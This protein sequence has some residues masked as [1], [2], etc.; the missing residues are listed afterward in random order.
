MN[1]ILGKTDANENVIQQ[2]I[3]GYPELKRRNITFKYQPN[4]EDKVNEMI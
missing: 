3:E 2:L 4:A 1:L